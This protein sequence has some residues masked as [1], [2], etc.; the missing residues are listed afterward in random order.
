METRLQFTLTTVLVVPGAN[1]LEHACGRSLNQSVQERASWVVIF[2]AVVL[3]AVTDPDLVQSGLNPPDCTGWV[4]LRSQLV[5]GEKCSLESPNSLP[6]QCME[7][8]EGV[9]KS[10][11]CR[12][13]SMGAVE[14]ETQHHLEEG[15]GWRSWEP[16][17]SFAAMWPPSPTASPQTD[18]PLLRGCRNS[19]CWK[20]SGHLMMAGHTG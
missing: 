12:R 14:K 18:P 3:R 2:G 11:A 8:V 5:V 9:V 7:E 19:T 1:D 15:G 4:Y 13:T 20:V 17:L 16:S 10:R 6:P